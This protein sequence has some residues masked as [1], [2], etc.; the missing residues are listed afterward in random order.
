MMKQAQLLRS[1]IVLMALV[2]CSQFAN[3]QSTP[4]ATDSVVVINAIAVSD[5]PAKIESLNVR[6]KDIEKSIQPSEQIKDLDSIFNESKAYLDDIKEQFDEINLE[7]LNLRTAENYKREWIG[8]KELLVSIRTKF[9]DRTQQL[10]GIFEELTYEEKVWNMTLDAAREE[11]VA[12]ELISSSTDVLS[13]INKLKKATKKQQDEVLKIYK[14]IGDEISILDEV[15]E[16]L[17]YRSKELHSMIFVQDSPPLWAS[18]DSTSSPGFLKR[19]IVKTIENNT[20]R[21][22]RLF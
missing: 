15:I 9:N 7:E 8:Y 19:Q 12:S 13:S 5:I 3:G 16:M 17:D 10:Q 21:I 22:D 4:V 14:G 6:I 20:R 11:K 2:L 18:I 1:I